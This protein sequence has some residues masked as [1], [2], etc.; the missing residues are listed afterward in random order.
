MTVSFSDNVKTKVLG[1][2]SVTPSSRAGQRA[3]KRLGDKQRVLSLPDRDQIRIDF[4]CL[5]SKLSHASR[6][7]PSR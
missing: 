7:Y 5:Q 3:D 4:L 6:V 2:A 1:D